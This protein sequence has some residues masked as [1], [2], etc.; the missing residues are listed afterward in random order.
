MSKTRIDVDVALGRSLLEDEV[1]GELQAIV[2]QIAPRWAA[3]LHIC[4]PGTREIPIV[5]KRPGSLGDVVKTHALK[6]G[7]RYEEL[8]REFGVSPYERQN[9]SR[10][11]MVLTARLSSLPVWMRGSLVLRRGGGC[12]ATR[13][14]PDPAGRLHRGVARHDRHGGVD[15]QSRPG[16]HLRYGRRARG[17]GDRQAGLDCA[18]ES[19]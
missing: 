9:A 10:N 18:S 17:R 5:V 15:R 7:P 13:S 14:R 8:V 2:R 6:R 12:S 4:E 16:H 1:L 11:C 3:G 19:G